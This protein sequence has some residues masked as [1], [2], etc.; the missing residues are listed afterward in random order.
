MPTGLR[1]AKLIG[2]TGLFALPWVASAAEARSCWMRDAVAPSPTVTYVLCEQG[3]IYASTDG[4][5]KWNSTLTGSDVSLRAIHFFD[6]ARGIVVGDRGTI[7]ATSDSGKTWQKRTS[8]VADHLLSIAAIGDQVWVGGFGGALI[9]SKDGGQ[10]WT[11]QNAG[12][13]QTLE[14]I[15]FL[16]KDHGWAVG[17]SGT[18]IRTANGGAKWEQIPAPANS[19]SL[20]AVH[21][22][23]LNNGLI[24]GF[25]GQL[26]GSKDGGATWQKLQSSMKGWL[27]SVA[28][29]RSNRIWITAD[30]DLMVSE[31]G[32]ATWKTVD[33]PENLFL[34]KLFKSGDNLLALGQLGLLKQAGTTLDW[35]P[36]DTLDPNSLTNMTASSVVAEAEKK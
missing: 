36:V 5:V 25:N 19:W 2:I 22:R 11:K 15:Y 23:D 21:F 18:I 34:C 17:W 13:K 26:F 32:G 28:V 14:G 31:D 7:M 24:A 8:G 1:L 27:K 33:L 10:T 20:T 16:D 4:G 6:T 12:S 3:K 35:K 9:A 30:S 29:D